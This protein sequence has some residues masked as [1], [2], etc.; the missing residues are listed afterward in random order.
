MLTSTRLRGGALVGVLALAGGLAL[1]T[2]AF[3]AEAPDVKDDPI[4]LDTGHIDAFNLVLNEDDT[5]RL[6]LKED[7]TGSHVLRTPESVTLAVKSQ[8]F[9]TNLPSAGVPEGAPTELYHLP[10]TQDH[11]L[12]WPGW[13]SQS[14]GSVYGSQAKVDIDVTAVD[15]PGEVFLWTT[16]QWGGVA[17]LLTEGWTFPGTIHQDFL[18]HVHANWGFT[19][20]GTYTLTAHADVTSADGTQTSTS[21]E[22]T[23]TFV[24][25][26]VPTALSVSGAEDE[27]AP[28][29]EVT[30]TAASSPAEAT[31]STYAWQ[32][33]ASAEAE[34]TTVDGA[35][36]STLTVDAVAGAQYRATVSGG[37][38]YASGSA[39]PIVVESDPVTIS[40]TGGDPVEQA[41][42]IAPLADHYHSGSPIDL[43]IVADPAVEDGA[44]RWY[45]QRTDQDQPVLID[46]ATGDSHRIPAAEQ[47]LDGAE[48]IAE[49][50]QDGTAL[51]TS[52]AVTIEVDDHGAAP[53]QKVSVGGIADHYHTG[54]TATLTASVTPASVLSRFEW[55]VQKAG[56]TIPVLVEGEND[57]TY[58]FSVTEDLAGAAVIATLTYDNGDSYVESAPVIVK[59]D[60]HGHEVPDTDLT[61]STNRDADDYWV[62]QTATL[63]A[64]QSTP[65]GLTEHQWLVKLPGADGFAAVDGQTAA[66]YTFKPTLANSGVQVKVQLLHDGEMHAESAPITITTQQREPVTTLTVTADKE[67]Y[68]AGETAQLTSTQNPQT[69]QSHYHWYVKRTGASD[70]VWVDQSRDKDLAYPVTAEDDGAQLV[71]RLFDDTH[72]MIAE[73]EP[74]TLAVATGGTHPQPTTELSIDGLAAGYHVGETATLTAVQNP[75]TDED[76]YHWFI[77][78][79]GDADFSVISGAGQATLTHEVAEADAGAQIV[80]KLYDHDHTLVAES[81][82]VTLTVRPGDPKPT[83]AP[84]TQTEDV[85]DG[86]DEGGITAS[87]TAPQ[88]GQVITVQVGE[89]A[90]HAGEWVAAWLFSDPVLLGGDWIQVGADGT[91]AVTIPA[92]TTAGTHRLAVFDADG[93]LIG[94]QQLQ[95]GAAA[96]GDPGTGAGPAGL[97][98]TGGEINGI[99]LGTAGVL[100]VAGMILLLARRRR[101]AD[102]IVS[103]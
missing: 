58:S 49:L 91:I 64:E 11:E 54:D 20:P 17:P 42:S 22:A 101:G 16:G 75:A 93:Q 60:D 37:K 10:L 2:A 25:A 46:G 55:Y 19:Q 88:A 77:Q 45:L 72:A 87:A 94:W 83:T 12:I 66:E 18:A 100:L 38:D 23:Y 59:L 103:E 7:V 41:I 69:D 52:E 9:S 73:S 31:F 47:A 8:A 89:G 56:E 30:L 3:A 90:E 6:V 24:V 76:H 36:T 44:Y 57:A 79:S 70:F 61:I 15:G 96:A 78:R 67:S 99:V 43:Q 92:D 50:V 21:N 98:S 62:G 4:H 27:V 51:A 85:L 81:A 65:T 74:H 1:P 40:T 34:W 80:A 53:L 82:P 14:V 5:A 29:S 32:T 33:R 13:D 63:T 102:G 84:S 28:G 86:V 71:L 26:P 35:A 68:A 39:Q 95:V 97:P 48:V